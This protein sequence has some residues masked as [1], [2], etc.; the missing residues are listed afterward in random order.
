MN[1][2]Y[3]TS[4]IISTNNLLSVVPAMLETSGYAI[5]ATCVGGASMFNI[6]SQKRCTKCGEWKNRGEFFKQKAAK[7]G[8]SPNCKKCLRE[9]RVEHGM[10]AEVREKNRLRMREWRKSEANAELDRERCRNSYW[11][12]AE[13][14]KAAVKKYRYE[15]PGKLKE[16]YLN[17]HARKKKNGG[18][19]TEKQWKELCDKYDNKCLCCGRSDVKLT[20]DHV[21]PLTMGGSNTI[22]NAQPLC[23]SCNSSKGNRRTTDYR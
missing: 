2:D 1:G 16:W 19:I 4:G 21:I 15:N 13:K 12:H 5:S 11:S 22:D 23:V 10:T 9:Y 17:Y 18:T 14:R 6:I 8:Y 20:L 7:D 3:L